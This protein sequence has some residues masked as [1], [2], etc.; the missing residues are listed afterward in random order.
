VTAFA[1]IR[2]TLL[3]SR[4]GQRAD[5]RRL[6]SAARG[7]DWRDRL[8]IT[9]WAAVVTVHGPAS[10]GQRSYVRAQQILCGIA[11][12]LFAAYFWSR[13]LQWSTLEA[14][15][16]KASAGGYE[17]QTQQHA[18]SGTTWSALG[19][20]IWIYA[21]LLVVPNLLYVFAHRHVDQ[22]VPTLANTGIGALL[23]AM[24]V[25]FIA[26][27]DVISPAKEKGGGVVWRWTLAGG[28]WP[29]LAFAIGILLVGLVQGY[30]RTR[31]SAEDLA[32]RHL[33]VHDAEISPSAP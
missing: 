8:A 32:S 24:T 13:T 25:Y 3:N 7:G 28:V 2:A 27:P 18:F 6:G 20:P 23:T 17:L 26:N 15:L 30:L 22:L 33:N 16:V 14:G 31:A 19:D 29:A 5:E 9:G 12:A 11:V 4:P 10:S 21:F 1:A